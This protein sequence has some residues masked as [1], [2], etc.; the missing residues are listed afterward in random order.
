MICPPTMYDEPS[1]KTSSLIP[2]GEE[3]LTV[4]DPTYLATSSMVKQVFKL[5]IGLLASRSFLIELKTA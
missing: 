3:C 4:K 2:C 5:I 1:C